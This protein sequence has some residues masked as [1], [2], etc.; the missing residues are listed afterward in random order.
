LKRKE[1]QRKWLEDISI[2]QIQDL[3]QTPDDDILKVYRVSQK[4][5]S[6]KHNNS[7]LHEEVDDD[8]LTLF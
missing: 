1:Q 3:L 6:V 2:E 7:D 5:N 8:L 4:I